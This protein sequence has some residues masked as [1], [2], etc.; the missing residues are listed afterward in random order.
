MVPLSIKIQ[1]AVLNPSVECLAH[2]LA[3]TDRCNRDYEG[4]LS[5][6]GTSSMPGVALQR[7]ASGVPAQASDR[8]PVPLQTSQ[9]AS[10]HV[11]SCSCQQMHRISLIPEIP[12]RRL[13]QVLG[14][15][16]RPGI[17]PTALD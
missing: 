16:N 6:A 5:H 3:L 2:A 14:P 4:P 17:V 9:Q 1:G 11:P 12:L 15:G 7:R 13:R 10:T 8:Q